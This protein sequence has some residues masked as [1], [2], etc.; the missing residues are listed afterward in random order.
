M[1]FGLNLSISYGVG[2]ISIVSN[3]TQMKYRNFLLQ[4]DKIPIVFCYNAKYLENVC[5]LLKNVFD[6]ELQLTWSY[7]EGL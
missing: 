5:T 1:I 7:V 3:F 2:L 4:Y 6:R